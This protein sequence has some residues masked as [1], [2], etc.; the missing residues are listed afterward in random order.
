MKQGN[1]T[2]LIDPECKTMIS[3]FSEHFHSKHHS[4]S[5]NE[6]NVEPMVKSS[7]VGEGGGGGCQLQ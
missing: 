7:R 6:R 1:K 5:E 2:L 3:I 4:S